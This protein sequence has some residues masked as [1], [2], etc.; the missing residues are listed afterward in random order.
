M[1]LKDFIINRAIKRNRRKIQFHNLKTAKFVSVLHCIQDKS[2]YQI[3]Q[4]FTKELEKNDITVSSL[5][6]V[7]NAEEIGQIYFGT[8]NNHFFSEK[9][10][11]K[12]GKIKEAAITNFLNRKTDILI[13]LCKENIF[14]TEYIFALSEAAFKVSG[15]QD[16]KHS[17]LKI[18]MSQTDNVRQFTEQITHYLNIINKG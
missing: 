8:N 3:L 14:C 4:D 9:N 18:S 13:N 7:R 5:S 17:D 16:C 15:I 10:I 12:F 2:D 11:S 1:N 6:F